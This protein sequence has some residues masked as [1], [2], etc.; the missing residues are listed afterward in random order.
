MRP[1]KCHTFIFICIFA[2]WQ[3]TTVVLDRNKW[4]FILDH[5][6]MFRN[7]SMCVLSLFFH[8]ESSKCEWHVWNYVFRIHILC[9]I[10]WKIHKTS[11]SFNLMFLMIDNTNIDITDVGCY[12]V[13]WIQLT[14]NRIHWQTVLNI[15]MNIQVCTKNRISWPAKQLSGFKWLWPIEFV[16]YFE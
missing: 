16:N 11:L 9:F 7:T 10:I 2:S 5:I 13:D 3:V 1:L 15:V 8:W 14:Q 12:A 4:I 6:Q